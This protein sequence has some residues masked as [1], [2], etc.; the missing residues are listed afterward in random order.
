[1]SGPSTPAAAKLAWMRPFAVTRSSLP[2]RL[3]IAPNCAVSNASPRV[4]VA[5]VTA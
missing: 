2:T 1:M 4:E 5:K 3:G